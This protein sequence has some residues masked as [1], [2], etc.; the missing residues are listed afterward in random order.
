[1]TSRDEFERWYR[2]TDHDDLF[3]QRYGD[4]YISPIMNAAWSAWV[5]CQR[6]AAADKIPTSRLAEAMLRISDLVKARRIGLGTLPDDRDAIGRI[7]SE[8][9]G[10]DAGSISP[11]NMEVMTP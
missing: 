2:P 6:R 3:C 5:E 4:G 7:A 8:L 9:V 1:M 11:S 10:M